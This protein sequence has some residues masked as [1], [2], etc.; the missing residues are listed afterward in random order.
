VKRLFVFE[1]PDGVG[2]SSIARGLHECLLN[3]G[4]KSCLL[5]FPGRE[6]GT[7]GALVYQIHHSSDSVGVLKIDPFALQMLHVAAHIDSIKQTIEP[8]LSSN[9][10]VILDRFWWST[11]AY[12]VADGLNR[13]QLDYLVGIEKFVWTLSPTA[14]FVVKCEKPFRN[15]LSLEQWEKLTSQY[16]ILI[17]Q[18]APKYP[19][20]LLE[21]TASLAHTVQETLDHSLRFIDDKAS[22]AGESNY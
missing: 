14:L 11:I 22:P 10:I 4:L 20:F 13:T 3:R 17:E 18:E 7:L 21:N 16:H 1:G 9:V 5:S 6:P 15:E 12:G 8:V 19:V 2:K